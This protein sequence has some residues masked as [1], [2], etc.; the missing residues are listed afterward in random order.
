ME[1]EKSRLDVG[2]LGVVHERI[3]FLV[4]LCEHTALKSCKDL[5]KGFVQIH[6]ALLNIWLKRYASSIMGVNHHKESLHS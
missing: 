4:A 6:I 2:L 3:A 5:F 1:T